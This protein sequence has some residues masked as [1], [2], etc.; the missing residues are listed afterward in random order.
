MVG[1]DIVIVVGIFRYSV[2]MPVALGDKAVLP[3]YMHS[4]TSTEK[5]IILPLTSLLINPCKFKEPPVTNPKSP[6]QNGGLWG[7]DFYDM[8]PMR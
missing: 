7:M 1:D 2:G 6:I 3:G 5:Y 8:V 4:I